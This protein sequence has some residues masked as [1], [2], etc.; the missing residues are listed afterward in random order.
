MFGTSLVPGLVVEWSLPSDSLKF[1]TKPSKRTFSAVAIMICYGFRSSPRLLKISLTT[2][3]V[4]DRQCTTNEMS[5]P[6]ALEAKL[7]LEC[8]LSWYVSS[9]TETILTLRTPPSDI[10]ISNGLHTGSDKSGTKST[11][12]SLRTSK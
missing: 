1:S 4:P 6:Y 11:L 8:T 9:V 3:S 2:A 5:L 10:A 12:P 7:I